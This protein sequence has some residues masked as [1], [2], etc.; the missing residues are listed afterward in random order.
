MLIALT[1]AVSSY[2]APADD[3]KPVSVA[4]IPELKSGRNRHKLP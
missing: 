2:D 3:E 4:S 1:V